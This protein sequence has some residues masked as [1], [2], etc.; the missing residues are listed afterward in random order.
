MNGLIAVTIQQIN[1]IKVI[2]NTNTNIVQQEYNLDSAKVLK[3]GDLVFKDN[4]SSLVIHK[5]Y[6]QCLSLSCEGRYNFICQTLI[7]LDSSTNKGFI[8]S[9]D[10]TKYPIISELLFS[11]ITVDVNVAGEYVD[12]FESM[13]TYK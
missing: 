9:Y 1:K 5:E 10:L 2:T 7:I 3:I 6:Y 11:F 13:E 8:T 12:G 4:Y